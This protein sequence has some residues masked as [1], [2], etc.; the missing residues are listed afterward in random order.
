ME[1]FESNAKQEMFSQFWKLCLKMQDYKI[2]FLF[3]K[4]W[5]MEDKYQN[6]SVIIKNF[7]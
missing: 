5:L 6:W 1:G 4:K 3:L 2:L 7:L